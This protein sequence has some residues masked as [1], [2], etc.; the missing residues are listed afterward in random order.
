MSRQLERYAGM[1]VL[2]VDDN[3]ANVA[4]LHQLLTHQGMDRVY[5]ETD[6]REVPRQLAKHKPDLVLLDLR[7]P[8]VDGFAVLAQIQT[9][10]A[11]GYLPVMVLTA[12]TTT[13]ARNQALAQGAQDFLTKPVDATEATL[14]IA[15][16]LQT[17]QLYATLRQVT[18]PTTTAQTQPGGDHTKVLARIQGVL[19]D[20]T[21][22]PVFQLI[23]DLTTRATVGHEALSR[24]PD[25]TLGGP[26]RWFADAF[27]VGLGVDL[28]WLA[29]TSVLTYL[30]TA[31]PEM[32]L[33]VNMSPA[34]AMHLVENQLCH[35]DLW[36]RIVIE[37]TEHVPVEDYAALHQ[38]LAPMRSLGARL[39][40]D[41]LGS[42]YAGF[43]HLLRLQPDI[44]KLDISLIAG[45]D[46]NHEQQA[47]TRALLTFAGDVG[48]Q[49]IAEGIEEPDE[50]SVLRDLGVPWGQGYL[51]GRP[52][53]LTEFGSPSGNSWA[54]LSGAD[55]RAAKS[56]DGI[57][58]R[59]RNVTNGHE[60]AA[61]PRPMIEASIDSMVTISP[62]GKIAN[63][64]QASAMLTR[65]PRE[66]VIGTS[67]S[68]YL[69]DPL[70]AAERAVVA[71]PT[72]PVRRGEPPPP[73][74][75]AELAAAI[76]NGELVLHYHP[77]V[78]LIT[79]QVTGV[80]ALVRWLHPKRGLLMPVDFIPLAEASGLIVQLGDWV[81]RTGAAQAARWA[82]R[83]FALDVAINLSAVQMSASAFADHCIAVLAAVQAPV[84]RI[85]FE[86]TESALLDQ[87]HAREGLI[88]LRKSGVRLALDD[89]GTGYSS[90][91]YLRR[92]PIDV[93][94]IDRSFVSGLGENVDDDAIVASVVD[95]A[96]KTG[97]SIIAEG[98]ETNA[99]LL[100]LRNLGVDAAQGFLWTRPLPAGDLEVWIQAARLA[101]PVLPVICPSPR[102][103]SRRASSE[104][105]VRILR[106]VGEGAS[107]QTIAAAL[108]RSGSQT[109]TGLRWHA[110]SVAQVI[111]PPMPP[112]Q[113]SSGLPLPPAR[114]P[115]RPMAS[116]A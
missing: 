10:A 42:G 88:K 54:E 94:K 7:M 28:E 112:R 69:T 105:E 40:A 3:A 90:F 2:V 86:V 82:A 32:F 73:D 4:F 111:S 18:V 31:P 19:Q 58:N 116:T 107:L 104:D 97:R 66:G 34:T 65:V 5:S 24:F 67:F 23:Q 41:D 89:F 11:G 76:D 53:P 33:A 22:T 27:T 101:G 48:A 43:R 9:F 51:L 39:S 25:P 78:E 49:V 71:E 52:A 20:K 8:H 45:I 35:P 62:E 36:P 17:R 91:S 47:L 77:V 96:R 12:D 21:L 14:R 100:H 64:K 16:L 83:G 95:L 87:P 50:L 26:D 99:Q 63:A 15:N 84:D 79:G 113:P 61:F 115:K 1:S 75:V 56:N 114:A 72:A 57:T 29:A 46:R 13:T 92:F 38:A 68:D 30:D 102:P 109:S 59:C 110:T 85:V 74:N 103:G 106:M 6:A 55:I 81:L 108:N 60:A 37:L 93:I 98:V 80:E 70:A 44:I